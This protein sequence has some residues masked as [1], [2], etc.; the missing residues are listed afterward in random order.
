MKQ[1]L[2]HYMEQSN[3]DNNRDSSPLLRSVSRPAAHCQLFDLKKDQEQ[4]WPASNLLNGS[5]R[6]RAQYQNGSHLVMSD[7]RLLV[8]RK[9]G[10][11]YC[12]P[13]SAP[14][15]DAY[16]QQQGDTGY[17]LLVVGLTTGVYVALLQEESPIQIVDDLFVG[18][19][20]P[21][22]K[23]MF[24]QNN[25]VV[26]CYGNADVE[27]Y[28][29]TIDDE[30]KIGFILSH[31]KRPFRILQTVTS[32]WGKKH[33]RDC[34]YDA[35][36]KNLFVLSNIDLTVWRY[37]TPDLFTVVSSVSVH[38]NAVAVLPS[39]QTKGC[40]TIILSDG[41]RQPVFLEKN[42]I[43]KTGCENTV[44]RLGSVRP[45]PTDLHLNSIQFACQGVDG[46][47]LLYDSQTCTVVMITVSSPIYEGIYDVVE[48]VSN[49]RLNE[50]V[51]GLDCISE[52]EDSCTTFVVY[53]KYGIIWSIS[54]RSLGLMLA[55]LLR[56][57]SLTDNVHSLLRG[58]EPQ[59]KMEAVMGAAFSGSS[60]ELLIPF[61]D[62]LMQPSF[63]EGTMSVSPGVR[64]LVNLAH[65][66]IALAQSLWDAPFSWHLMYDLQRV[67]DHLIKWYE[68]LDGLLR[69]NGWLDCPKQ[70]E[71]SWNGLVA[72]SNH[73]F[74]IR[75]ALNAQALLLE[76]VLKGFQTA[77]IL[78]WLYTLL[79][80]LKPSNVDVT[81]KRL[82]LIVWGEDTDQIINAFCMEALSYHDKD[83]LVLL[84]GKKNILPRR[85]RH[86]I[87]IQILISRNLPDA[88]LSYACDNVKSLRHEEMFDYVADELERSFPERMPRLRLL[89]Y[90]LKHHRSMVD[91]FQ[92]L[93]N[94]AANDSL[95][96]L[97]LR[98]GLVMQAAAD[99][100]ILQNAVVH[101][102]ESHSL[103]DNRIMTFAE[104]LEE[105][106]VI[107]NEPHS[108]TALFF[109]CWINRRLNPVM[110]ARGFGDIAKSKHHLALSMRISCIKLALECKL[111]TSEQLVYF[112]LLLQEELGNAVE[113][114]WG[115]N[116]I[117]PD[118]V[119]MNSGA[120]GGSIGRVVEDVEDVDGCGRSKAMT[121]VRELRHFYVGEQRLFEL[122]GSYRRQGGAKVQLDLLKVHPETP[123]RVTVAVLHDLLEF[124]LDEGMSPAEAVR[125]VAREY[126]DAYAAGL[127]LPPLLRFSARCGTTVAAGAAALRDGGVPPGAIFDALLALIDEPSEEVVGVG[128][129]DVLEALA[130][131]LAKLNGEERRLRGA[132]VLERIHHRLAGEHRSGMPRDTEVVQLQHAE[133]IVRRTLATSPHV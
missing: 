104:V 28:E 12:P 48:V 23:I 98:L 73:P 96:K 109:L 108:L 74:T 87:S 80:R 51:V 113:A 60:L 63:R 67:A 100:P 89:L 37:V 53:G 3:R 20:H 18:T 5:G 40:A 33:Y 11:F 79:L 72:T 102:M 128:A 82:D 114:V 90:S 65:D 101:W 92:M 64:S 94:S 121:D 19:N 47:I 118:A 8:V 120:G 125:N 38:G 57:E 122:A 27:T 52:L 58:L 25:V 116:S 133:A 99:D 95:E 131:I 26:L 22:E 16:I 124:L 15:H 84:E 71:L 54:V 45:L 117:S 21:V 4:I 10:Y 1:A 70:V 77:G 50:T 59:R 91:L 35:N 24:P 46:T 44:L 130:E 83:V 69:P 110:A 93:D 111:T 56:Q 2:L 76:T 32:L 115:T 29:V 39:S 66:K 85:A 126:Y 61:L 103:E 78:S 106:A 81:R 6:F 14:I 42:G 119:S 62:E 129:G 30:Q 17:S 34:A 123:P 55:D 9:N 107:I 36:S 86:G 75:S 105:N 7:N 88:A 41:G 97:K 49:L 68:N 31:G 127:P 13:W 43:K 132:Y 112:V